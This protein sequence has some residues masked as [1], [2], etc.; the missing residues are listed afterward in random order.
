MAWQ[1]I[2][3]F[4]IMIL[5]L[6]ELNVSLSQTLNAS[7]AQNQKDS[8]DTSISKNV[9][10]ISSV[11]NEIPSS[12]IADLFYKAFANFTV[13]RTNNSACRIQTELYIKHL[14][15]HSY[16]ATQMAD[17]WS[18]YPTGI[19]VGN[20]YQMGVYDECTDVKFPIRGQYCL[21]DITL[22]TSS[23][24]N[25]SIDIQNAYNA[26]NNSW[27]QILR[28]VEHPN[29]MPRNN[30]KFGICVPESCKALD[31]QNSLQFSLDQ[32]FFPKKIKAIAFVDPI[33]CSIST[34][35]YPYTT[36]YY[37]TSATFCV[38]CLICCMATSVHFISLFKKENK[39][40][41]NKSNGILHSFSFIK[42]GKEL[43]SYDKDNILNIMN[44]FKL[45]IMIFLL[46]GH[47]YMY[48]VG[49]PLSYPKDLETTY[50]DGPDILLTSMN[51]VDPYFFMSG[52][53]VY[54]MLYSTL[55]GNGSFSYKLFIP[56]IYRIIRMMPGY[57]AVIVFTA[58]LL[59]HFGDGP[60]WKQKTWDE[61]NICK[62]YWWTNILFIN[63]FIDVK[64]QCLIVSWYV[65]CDIHFYVV[66][67][68]LLYIH[69][70]NQKVGLGIIIVLIF[71]SLAMPFYITL[72]T[73]S[74][75][76]VKVD[77]PFLKNPR[78]S[79][80]FNK[81][82]RPSYTR[83]TPF[84]IGLA[85]NFL[86]KKLNEKK[87]K[88]SYTVVYFGTLAFTIIGL[89][90][91]FYG[92]HFYNKL[93]PY[94]LL[95]NALYASVSHCTWTLLASWIVICY[96]TSSYGPL[97]KIL[98]NRFVVPL[99]RLS[100]CVFLVNLTVMTISSST[101]RLPIHFTYINLINYCMHDIFKSY[102]IGALLYFTIDAPISDL[103]KIVFGRK[104][105][106]RKSNEN[107]KTQENTCSPEDTQNE[108][109]VIQSTRL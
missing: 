45:L 59:P 50:T 89:W 60:F 91:Q 21:S 83:A 74:D 32:V 75:G 99:G 69:T 12:Q 1:I 5:L 108:T 4:L 61:A 73:K 65:A 97:A 39:K 103:I 22:Y 51:L 34:D 26:Y 10:N 109:V 86:V 98:N 87:F 57:I 58:Q 79:L 37:L 107:N 42:N 41:A 78:S 6:I 92:V 33:L 93:R 2:S 68:I 3:I 101:E 38:L 7:F 95:E 14:K 53:L 82:Y 104:Q 18:R 16:W 55:S 84:F 62:D 67:V 105:N 64:Y 29:Q 54:T 19:L 88:M 28:W 77:I 80:T 15:N 56:I 30:L 85:I 44:G 94:N 8:I 76:I 106:Y 46:F 90:A 63:N 35:L 66:G 96:F 48:M 43:L 23:S 70:K 40:N 20:N 25:H 71:L 102:L 52:F 47:R 100:Y 24:S 49:M 27:D 31:V 81:S 72:I 9:W 17:S 11:N 13:S 36:G